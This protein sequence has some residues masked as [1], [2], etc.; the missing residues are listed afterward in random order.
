MLLQAIRVEV[1]LKSAFNSLFWG[2]DD[3]YGKML[4]YKRTVVDFLLFGDIVHGDFN[5]AN[6]CATSRNFHS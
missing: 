4:D 6:T 2:L 5:R 1:E 3:L